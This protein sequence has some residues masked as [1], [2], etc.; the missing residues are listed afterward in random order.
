[1]Q[2]TKKAIGSFLL[3]VVLA[4]TI[5]GSVF[6]YSITGPNSSQSPYLLR[7]QPGVI[8]N[9]ILTVGDS[10]SMKP[11]GVTPYRMVGLPDGLGAFHNGDGTFTLLMNHEL[12]GANGVTRAKEKATSR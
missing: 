1:M 11:D 4:L 2:F 8:T 3:V 12:T 7:S 6:A 9:A 5:V 10:V